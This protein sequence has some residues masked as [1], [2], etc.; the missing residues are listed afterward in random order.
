LHVVCACADASCHWPPG[1]LAHAM[2]AV[3]EHAEDRFLP[4]PHVPHALQLALPFA[5]WNW[6]AS[7][8][9]HVPVPALPLAHDAH[10]LLATLTAQPAPDLQEK[11]FATPFCH[12][13]DGQFLQVALPFSFWNVPWPH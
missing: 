2:L 7:H 4:A 12:Q 5:F 1:Q 13:L 6:P 11:L 9:A 8:S 10:T 3:A